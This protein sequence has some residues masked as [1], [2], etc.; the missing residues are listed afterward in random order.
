MYTIDHIG[1]AGWDPLRLSICRPRDVYM[2]NDWATDSTHFAA[3][4]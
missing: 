1:R 3:V 2:S 4:F